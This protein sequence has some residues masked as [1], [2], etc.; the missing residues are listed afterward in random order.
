[1]PTQLTTR[2]SGEVKVPLTPTGL[3]DSWPQWSPNGALIAGCDGNTDFSRTDLG[4][5]LVTADPTTGARTLVT[6]LTEPGDGFPQGGVWSA[7]SLWLYAAGTV[8]GLHGV[9][10]V[11]ATGGIP[12]PVSITSVFDIA[13]GVSMAPVVFVGGIV[14]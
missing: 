4:H 6:Q 2:R 10:R 9:W 1:M 11:P 13:P 3:G 12:Q 7:N 8:D 5:N 14:P